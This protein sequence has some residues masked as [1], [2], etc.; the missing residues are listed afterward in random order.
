MRLKL[1]V[2]AVGVGLGYAGFQEFQVGSSAKVEPAQLE[3]GDIESGSADLSNAHVVVGPHQADYYGLI[4][5]P[6]GSDGVKYSF[7]PI[8]SNNHSFVEGLRELFAKYPDGLPEDVQ[9]PKME[10]LKVMVKTERFKS[11]DDFPNSDLTAEDQI[12]GLFINKIST[13]KEDEITLL[14]ESY[15]GVNTDEI[16]ILEEDRK[17]MGPALYFGML[18]GGGLIALVGVAWM[19]MGFSRK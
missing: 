5:M 13:L 17:P 15:P 3:L 4:Y 2:I 16:L 19:V 6:S 7:Y 8:L 1:I 11:Q 18:G 10:N 9:E 12:Q 14:R